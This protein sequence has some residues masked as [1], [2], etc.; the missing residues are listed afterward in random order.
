MSR[1]IGRPHFIDVHQ[2]TMEPEKLTETQKEIRTLFDSQPFAVLATQGDGITDA[3][4]VT[5]AVSEDLSHIVFA[6]PI[7]TG[8][9]DFIAA[10]ENVSIL[11]DD[12]TLHQNDINQIS[13]LT[14]LGKAKI[15]SSDDEIKRWGKL[16]MDQHPA[17]TEFVQAPTSAIVL[18]HV[19][20]YLFVKHFQDIR[21][22]KLAD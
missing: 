9:Y 18:I 8:K 12:R 6:T 15:L 5:I 14:V 11:V 17:L 4:L 1:A 10:N 2:N 22:W 16:L 7:R 21:E 13:A 20:K 3:S 19:T